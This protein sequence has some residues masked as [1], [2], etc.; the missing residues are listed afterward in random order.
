[1]D[2]DGGLDG[3]TVRQSRLLGASSGEVGRRKE[4]A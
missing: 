1:M 4:A 3:R 2:I